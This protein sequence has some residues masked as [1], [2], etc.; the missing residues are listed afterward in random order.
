MWI[1]NGSLAMKVTAVNGQL[2]IHHDR[3]VIYFHSFEDGGT[4]LRICRLPTPIPD[5]SERGCDVTHMVGCDWGG[6]RLA[7]DEIEIVQRNIQESI[8]TDGPRP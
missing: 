3:G 2:E 7:P 1:T 4:K 6:R 8:N 5:L